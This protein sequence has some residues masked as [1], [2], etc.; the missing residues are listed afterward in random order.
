M[1]FGEL[2]LRLGIVPRWAILPMIQKQCVATHCF[3]VERIARH[4]ATEIFGIT[5]HMHLD[6]ISQ[7]A[8]HHD[9]EEAIIGDIPSP[10]KQYVKIFDIIC[11]QPPSYPHHVNI[12]KIAD[13]METY[14]FIQ[15]DFKMGN[16]YIAKHAEM[17][18]SRL[19]EYIHECVTDPEQ[20]QKLEQF[21]WDNEEEE[22]NV[23]PVAG[24]TEKSAK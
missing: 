15:R 11:P 8:L 18:A 24:S 13:L 10:G 9:D 4:I 5:E 17:L 12:V 23:Y 21:I 1:S 22:S 19:R 20:V 3:L 2:D 7:W 16:M 14:F 6:E